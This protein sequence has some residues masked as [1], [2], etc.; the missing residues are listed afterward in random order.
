MRLFPGKGPTE[1]GLTPS[2]RAGALGGRR[3][4]SRVLPVFF[5]PFPH[6]VCRRAENPSPA[7]LSLLSCRATGNTAA[8]L[9]HPFRKQRSR[10][11]TQLRSDCTD[12]PNV[13]H[14]S[15]ALSS[16]DVFLCRALAGVRCLERV[17]PSGSV[18]S[19]ARSDCT[20]PT[21][22]PHPHLPR[23]GTQFISG[24]RKINNVHMKAIPRGQVL[25]V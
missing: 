18:V 7:L 4:C 19:A 21:P 13:T 24:V 11:E 17:L 25:V 8:A 5:F 10:L 9:C 6:P 20:S 3:R 22:L 1:A 16:A 2:I 12:L 15:P 23:G 14:R